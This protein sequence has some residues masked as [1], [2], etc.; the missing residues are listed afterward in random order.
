VISNSCQFS[1]YVQYYVFMSA[2]EKLLLRIITDKE[3]SVC[4]SSILLIE[5][6]CL[7]EITY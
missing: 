7:E 6:Q 4:Q 5:T 3:H 1:K 2:L